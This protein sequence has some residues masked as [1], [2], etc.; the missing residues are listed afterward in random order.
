MS[1]YKATVPQTTKMLENLGRWL[2]EA[3]ALA[4]AKKFDPEVL[5]ATRLAPDQYNLT[6]QIQAVCDA[7]KSMAA[8]LAGKDVPS[9][10]DT[11]TTLPELRARIQ[12]T[13]DFLGTLTE[14]DFAGA[15]DR[16]VPL[17]FLPIPDRALS[18]G[19][20]L[21]EL[22]LPNFYFHLVTAYAILRHCGV[23]L[24]KRTFIGSMN[25]QEL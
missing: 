17:P 9:H 23:G 22:S 21:N 11:E 7:A 4:E 18:A 16:M 1:L 6:Q 10:P 2:D 5:L 12:M 19:D 20:Y 25:L 3:V 24:G 8:R 14:A 13:L 15:S